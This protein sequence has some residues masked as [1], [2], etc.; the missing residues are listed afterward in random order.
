MMMVR[1]VRD[2]IYCLLPRPLLNWIGERS[3]NQRHDHKLYGLQPE[4][5]WRT[6]TL[7]LIIK[8]KPW[9]IISKLTH[10][11]QWP[12]PIF[13]DSRIL[14]QRSVINDDLAG[15]ILVGELVMKPNVQKFQGSTLVFDDGTVEEKIDAVI[16][17]TGYD[18]KFPFLPASLN[19]GADGDLRLYKRIFPPSLEH[20]TLAIMGLLQTRGPI[21]PAVELQAR[22]AT[23][24]IAGTEETWEVMKIYF[25]SYRIS[26]YKNL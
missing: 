11:S 1:R 9:Q 17:C 4:H 22:W 2:L 13:C 10:H 8:V 20:P 6:K 26:K 24:V 3:S 14:D 23:R 15:R 19:S 21:M 7:S 12:L 25:E 16:L 5:R 18:Y